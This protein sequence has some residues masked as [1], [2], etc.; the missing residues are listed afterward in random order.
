MTRIHETIPLEQMPNGSGLFRDYALKLGTPVHASIGEFRAD[1]KDW[2]VA[3]GRKFRADGRLVARLVEWNRALGAGPAV[4]DGLRGLGDG[5]V[6]A[7]IT[8]QQPGVAGGPLMTLH[9]VAAACALARTLER[10]QGVRCVPLFW[11]GADDDDFTEIREMVALAGDLSLVSSS[12]ASGA[13]VPGRRIGD[14]DAAAIQ[15]VWSAVAPHL[16]AG[17]GA[18]VASWIAGSRDL[19]DAAA[20]C[21]VKLTGGEV[22]VVDGREPL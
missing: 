20:R 10:A 22:A 7:V 3:A 4:L 6:R 17:A 19:G 12:I 11:M 16:P 9:K 8:G 2:R 15:E 18:D 1:A 14:I 5:S 21:I 13:Y